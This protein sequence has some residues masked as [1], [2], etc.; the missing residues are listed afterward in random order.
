MLFQ[1]HIHICF[2]PINHMP[3]ETS[4]M[5]HESQWPCQGHAN[6]ITRFLLRPDTHFPPRSLTPLRGSLHS[7]PQPLTTG[8]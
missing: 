4:A 3:S 7:S 2:Y 8:P 5:S 1:S 6:G